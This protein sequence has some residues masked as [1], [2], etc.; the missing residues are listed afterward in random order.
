MGV[1]FTYIYIEIRKHQRPPA[2]NTLRGL[3]LFD[4]TRNRLFVMCTII[5][6]RFICSIYII[7][8][9]VNLSSQFF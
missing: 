5:F 3:G 9:V 2:R 4:P 6:F 8:V 1:Y 7:A